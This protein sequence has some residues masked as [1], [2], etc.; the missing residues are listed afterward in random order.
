MKSLLTVAALLLSCSSFA[1]KRHIQ[2]ATGNLKAFDLE[3]N[4]TIDG[5]QISAPRIIAKEGEKETYIQETD[6]QKSIIEVVAK[7]ETA[8]DGKAAINMAFT[9]SR[10]SEDGTT[11]VISQPH[12]L[13]APNSEAQIEV[14]GNGRPQTISMKVVAN[15][16]TF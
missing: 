1:A 16:V 7:E 2:P 5:Q 15:K 10:V 12:I 11:T 8:P 6:G 13:A 9:I 3:M 14:G 4:L